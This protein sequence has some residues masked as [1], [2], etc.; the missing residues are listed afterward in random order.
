MATEAYEYEEVVETTEEENKNTEED[1]KGKEE[2][3]SEESGEEEDL[4]PAQELAQSEGWVPEDEWKGNKDEWIDYREFNTRGE[5]MKRIQSQSKQIHPLKE[6]IS[7]L[8][9]AMSFLGEHN[10]KIAEVEYNRAVKDLK[11]QKREARE[12]DDY[13]A[14]DEID[15][16]LDELKDAKKELDAKEDKKEES[17]EVSTKPQELP[18]AQKQI[19]KDWYD[20]PTNKWYQEEEMLR[21]VADQVFISRL[22]QNG[23]DFSEAFTYM[24]TKMK[25]KFPEE[26]GGSRK[27]GGSVTETSGRA[28]G[29]AKGNSK[30]PKFSKRDLNEEQAAVAK[31]FVDTGVFENIQEYVDQ[32]VEI[33]ELK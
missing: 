8:K 33:G 12:E 22:E 30:G 2:E 9:T 6:E 19:V 32:L 4:S 11:A 15:G 29:R 20:S 21:P 26:T 24:E 18:P 23:G 10:K 17:T 16:Q 1:N 14:I 25:S 27:K 28:A 3:L 31:T 7:E 5:L 13:A